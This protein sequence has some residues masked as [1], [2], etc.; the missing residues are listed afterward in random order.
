MTAATGTLD[1]AISPSL[2]NVKR[3]QADGYKVHTAEGGRIRTVLSAAKAIIKKGGAWC[4][5]A[6]SGFGSDPRTS[7]ISDVEFGDNCVTTSYV[8]PRGVYNCSRQFGARF[9]PSTILPPS[10]GL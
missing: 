9:P 8:A 7:N 6:K 2:C 10:F 3:R 5:G 4:R 1:R